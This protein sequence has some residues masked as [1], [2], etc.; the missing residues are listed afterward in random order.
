MDTSLYDI[1]EI[2][3]QSGQQCTIYQ[4]IRDRKD[5]IYCYE[6][7]DGLAS[8]FEE[9][10][11]LLC[12]CETWTPEDGYLDPE[13]MKKLQIKYNQSGKQPGYMKDGQF[14]PVSTL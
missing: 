10:I 2:T 5:F 3:L 7:G 1:T 9:C 11:Y 14:I 8:S 6:T 12:V 4:G 13:G